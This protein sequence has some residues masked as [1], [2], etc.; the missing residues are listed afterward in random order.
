MSSFNR[1]GTTWAGGSYP[2]L[3]EVLREEWGF[4]GMVITDYNLYDYM[5]ADQMIR[6]GGDLNLTQNK[7]PSIK[8]ASATQIALIRQ[9]TKNILYT[10]AG[11]NAMNGYGEGVVYRYAM[12][13][14]RVLLITFDCAA[15]VGFAVWGFFAIKK[16][17]RR[18]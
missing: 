7:Q 17:L 6:A 18:K 8:D 4:K 12:P 9:A 10:V 2:L 16:S 14:W 3:T 13:M 15:V 11:S 1:L 5:P